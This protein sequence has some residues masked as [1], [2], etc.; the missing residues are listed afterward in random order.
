[1]NGK[2]LSPTNASSPD[3]LTRKEFKVLQLIAS[4]LK[5]KEIAEEFKVSPR[6]VETQRAHILKK[7]KLRGIANLVI[8]ALKYEIID[9]SGK[10]T[11]K[12]W[13]SY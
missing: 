8:Y 1:M 9:K 11:N 3:T 4:G 6:T 2:Y 12:I 13:A 7:L 10:P 5:T